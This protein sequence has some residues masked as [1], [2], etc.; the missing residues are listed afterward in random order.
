MGVNCG[1][2]MCINNLAFMY[3]SGEGVEQNYTK[4]MDFYKKL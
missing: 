4:A 2:Y 3:D 1:D